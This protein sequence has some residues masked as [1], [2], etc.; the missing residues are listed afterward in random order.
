MRTHFVQ[1]L[2]LPRR[3]EA[4]RVGG[5]LRFPAAPLIVEDDDVPASETVRPV[6]VDRLEVHARS[7]MDR[8]QRVDARPR[9]SRDLVEDARRVRHGDVALLGLLGGNGRGTESECTARGKAGEGDA[10]H[11][12]WAAEW[13]TRR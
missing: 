3:D 9:V 8:D 11:S 10:H 5:Q 4:R 7:A 13:V 2:E 12:W 1:V 6:V